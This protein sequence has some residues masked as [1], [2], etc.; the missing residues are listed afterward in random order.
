MIH[1]MN[2]MKG[3]KGFLAI[4]VDLAKAYDRIRWS[5]I[6]AI[7]LEVGLPQGM[8]HLIM[9]CITSVKTNVLWNGSRSGFFFSRQGNSSG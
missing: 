7:F 9:H 3:K 8:I 6:H 2:K 1:S 5:F 4:K